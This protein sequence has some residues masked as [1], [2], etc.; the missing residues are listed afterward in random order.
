MVSPADPL[1]DV[2]RL[3]AELERTTEQVRALGRANLLWKTL[4]IVATILLFGFLVP[5]F[6][7]LQHAV[8]LKH[9]DEQRISRQQQEALDAQLDEIRKAMEKTLQRHEEDGPKQSLQK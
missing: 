2:I 9:Q 5:C 4:A 1:D 7:L 3:R 6:A 8:T